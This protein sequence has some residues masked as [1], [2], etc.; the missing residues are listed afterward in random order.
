MGFPVY[1][2]QLFSGGDTREYQP[3]Q[4]SIADVTGDGSHDVVLLC[5][6]RILI[7]PQ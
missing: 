6:D 5:H 7:Y 4:I 2:S 1:E 3:R